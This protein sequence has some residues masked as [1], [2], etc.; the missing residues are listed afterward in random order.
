MPRNLFLDDTNVEKVRLAL[1]SHW[2][3]F[4]QFCKQIKYVSDYREVKHL[5]TC[6]SKINR[7]FVSSGERTRFE[8]LLMYNFYKNTRLESVGAVKGECP[9]L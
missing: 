8:P 9:V 5:S 4:F 1:N 6:S 7:E 2:I 3:S